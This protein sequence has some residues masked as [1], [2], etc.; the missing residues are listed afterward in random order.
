MV[1]GMKERRPS[2]RL[3]LGSLWISSIRGGVEN[4]P[5]MASFNKG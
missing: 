1:P 2:V 3:G 5:N 4:I